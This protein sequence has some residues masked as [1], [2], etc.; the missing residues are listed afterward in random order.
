MLKGLMGWT[1]IFR[2]FTKD[3]GLHFSVWN[4]TNARC[5]RQLPNAGTAD[6]ATGL[7]V[8]GIVSSL[9]SL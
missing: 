8:G 4:T 1:I 2:W 5:D 3:V 6:H 7:F 9:A